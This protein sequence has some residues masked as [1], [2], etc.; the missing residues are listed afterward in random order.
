MT[1]TPP[2]RGTSR[3]LLVATLLV[4]VATVMLP[5]SPFSTILGFTPLP[6][7]YLGVMGVIVLLYILAAEMAKKVFYRYSDP[8]PL[9]EVD[10]DPRS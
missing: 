4:V 9:E 7:L 2:I 1:P 6:G 5:Y 10:A 3:Y 8:R